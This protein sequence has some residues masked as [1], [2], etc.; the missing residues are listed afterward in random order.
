MSKKFIVVLNRNNC[1]TGD[2]DSTLKCITKCREQMFKNINKKYKEFRTK[3]FLC[4]NMLINVTEHFSCV[5]MWCKLLCQFSKERKHFF[6]KRKKLTENI[7]S[8]IPVGWLFF[9]RCINHF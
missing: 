6:F 4:F 2:M 5:T 9:L 1:V 8:N 7:Y 3:G